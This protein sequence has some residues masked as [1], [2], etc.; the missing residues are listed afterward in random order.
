MQKLFEAAIVVSFCSVMLMGY[1]YR[2]AGKTSLLKLS[3]LMLMLSVA[4]FLFSAH[5]NA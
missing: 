4:G 2:F 5:V 1:Q 3:V